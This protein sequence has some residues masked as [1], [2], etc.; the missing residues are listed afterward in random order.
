[1]NT[2]P[3]QFRDISLFALILASLLM[4]ARASGLAWQTNAHSVALLQDVKTVWQFNYAT[5]NA[6]K[7][8]FHPLALPGGSPLTWQ[9]PADH[10][11]HY[12]L[13]FSW[14]YVNGVNYWEEDKQT[15]QSAGVTS[16]RVVKL[17]TRPDFS[18]LIELALD[19]RPRGA[20][21]AALTE[22]RE[23][24][25]S[26]PGPD[27]S[28]FMDW[29]LA[30]TAGA[31]KL[32]FDRTPLPGEPN[33]Q[34]YG[35]YAGLS[36][37]F[38]KGLAECEVSATADIGEARENRFRFAASGADYSGKIKGAKAGVAFLDHPSDP[39][40]PGRWYTIINPA[41]SFWFLNAAWIQ[42]QPYELEAGQS[43][44][45]RYRVVVHPGR[46]DKSKLEK[47]HQK[48]AEQK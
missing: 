24:I 45:L 25:V 15:R 39:R 18:A 30:F 31:E 33:G 17:E 27:G 46:W 36:M 9:S 16:W 38:A 40:F 37:R 43:F 26:A 4:N 13:W 32:K 44:T 23:I 10:P 19:Y 22:R 7:P 41:Q 3:K 14:K 48:F 35:G 29:K 47:E 34:P 12:G 2:L 20:T 42:L 1:M 5:T 8:F 11:W 21:N 6:S 28:Y